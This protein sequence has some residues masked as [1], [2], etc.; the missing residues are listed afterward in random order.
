MSK[1][2]NIRV[3][4]RG[5]DKIEDFDSA[6]LASSVAAAC[7]SV[8]LPDGVATDTAEQVLKSVASWLG[9]KSEVTSSDLRRVATRTLT[10]VSPE[11]G[12][13]YKHHHTIL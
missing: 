10:T 8:G 2:A 6:K 13:L 12:Y 1:Q 4:K 11:A 3:V 5:G 9:N 7:R